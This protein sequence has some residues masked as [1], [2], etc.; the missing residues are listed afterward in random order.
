MR[1]VPVMRGGGEE[2]GWFAHRSLWWFP[3]LESSSFWV[4]P[5]KSVFLGRS[6]TYGL[7]SEV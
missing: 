7:G 3:A 4:E 2:W 1:G 5:D 6:S